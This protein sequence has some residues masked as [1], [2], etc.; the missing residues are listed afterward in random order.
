MARRKK[1]KSGH[2]SAIDFDDMV[3]G[4]VGAMLFAN[5][6]DAETM[7]SDDYRYVFPDTGDVLATDAG[8]SAVET[9]DDFLGYCLAEAPQDVADY[10]RDNGS[11]S[12]GSDFAL[13]R[14]GHG[15]GFFDKGYDKLQKLAKTFG[16]NTWQ[17]TDDNE[18]EILE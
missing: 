13:S 9:C 2:R 16:P 4:Y 17:I 14:N 18:L 5:T 10:E 7:E 3:E 12:F 15:S 1:V 6:V 11:E 8:E